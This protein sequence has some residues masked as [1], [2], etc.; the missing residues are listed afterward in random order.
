MFNQYS[1]LHSISTIYLLHDTVAWC[2]VLIPRRSFRSFGDADHR[3]DL[4]GAADPSALV[5]TPH[6]LTNAALVP[7]S[8]GSTAPL[9]NFEASLRKNSIASATSSGW[10]IRPRGESPEGV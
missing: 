6:D 10:A 7:P 9:T 4:R 5:I 3:R 1:E 8:T 2:L